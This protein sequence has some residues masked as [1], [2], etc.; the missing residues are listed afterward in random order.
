MHFY[1]EVVS[2]ANQ[3]WQN[4][5]LAQEHKECNA[6][7]LEGQLSV[8]YIDLGLGSDSLTLKQ[9]R[10]ESIFQVIDNITR[11]KGFSS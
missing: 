3:P 4:R 5:V 6:C 2:V 11:T 9:G 1:I 8:I 10:E 7:S